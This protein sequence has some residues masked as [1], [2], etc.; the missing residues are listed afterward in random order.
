MHQLLLA[1]LLVRVRVRVRLFVRSVHVLVPERALL[2][3]ML[4]RRMRS[5]MRML[6][7]VRMLVPPAPHSFSLLLPRRRVLLLCAKISACDC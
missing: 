6:M 1:C 4:M 3:F 5:R 7:R 2:A